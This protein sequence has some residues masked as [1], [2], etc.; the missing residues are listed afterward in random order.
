MINPAHCKP[1]EGRR[2]DDDDGWLGIISCP[3]NHHHLTKEEEES[4]PSRRMIQCIGSQDFSQSS[5]SWPIQ[6]ESRYK[7][8]IISIPH[9]HIGAH[10]Q[11]IMMASRERLTLHAFQWDTYSWPRLETHHPP[12]RDQNP[13]PFRLKRATEGM[14]IRQVAKKLEEKNFA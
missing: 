11:I 2:R 14:K 3:R 10:H 13:F 8:A 1:K 5:S 12:E 4:E 7:K 9:I 6:I